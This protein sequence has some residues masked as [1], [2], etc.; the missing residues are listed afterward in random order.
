MR[1]PELP[2]L[3]PDQTREACAR[4]GLDGDEMALLKPDMTAPEFAARLQAAGLT[5]AAIR[6]AAQA[7]PKEEAVRWGYELVRGNMQSD[8]SVPQ[9]DLNA[10]HAVYAWIVAPGEEARRAAFDCV[11][12]VDPETPSVWLAY[13][14]AWSGGSMVRDPENPVPPPE[15]LT[16]V[17][18][19]AA[20]LMQSQQQE[21]LT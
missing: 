8:A 20:V 6:F 13:A 11:D 7:L 19:A 15:H 10:L 12:D 17:A 14:V 3:S 18:V 21:A 16:G 4:A 9:R 5:D 1:V 2:N